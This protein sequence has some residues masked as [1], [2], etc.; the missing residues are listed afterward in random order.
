M[1]DRFAAPA[2]ARK[3]FGQ[4]Y[5]VDDAIV[6]AIIDT[7]APQ[8]GDH[9]L[10]IGPGGGVLTAALV[11][12]GAQVVAIE[13]DRDL[14]AVLA[15]RYAD[16]PGFQLHIGDVLRFDLALLGTA[17]RQW[18]A[19]GNL[20][21][22]IS[23]PLIMRLLEQ[24]DRFRALTLMVQ[25]EVAERLAAGPGSTAYGRLSIMAQRRAR[26]EIRIAVGPHSFAPPPKVDS[27]VVQL[28]PFDTRFDPIVEEKLALL[29]RD[30]FGA[31]RKT[32]ANA[33]RPHLDKQLLVQCNIDPGARAEALGVDDFVNLARAVLEREPR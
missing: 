24:A 6:D 15:S 30:A 14:A 29:V 25:R 23:T 1:S 8:V 9:I 20:P 2:L 7:V 4:H 3:R 11:A 27:A 18:K 5:L 19:V 26:I 13:I 22:N 31:R 16:V 28:E 17:R 32:I 33:L 10:E 12:S 21:Y